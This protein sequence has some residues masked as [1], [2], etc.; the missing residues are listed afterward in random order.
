MANLHEES[1]VSFLPCRTWV[2]TG[3]AGFIGSHLAKA[4]VARGKAPNP[5][6]RR[7]FPKSG[8]WGLSR[9]YLYRTRWR[10]CGH[11]LKIRR[12]EKLN[13]PLFGLRA[14]L[15]VF[16]LIGNFLIPHQAKIKNPGSYKTRSLF[17]Y[18]YCQIY[19][20]GLSQIP[21]VL[22]RRSCRRC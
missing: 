10:K 4:L 2:I 12:S 1:A 22:C 19:F 17:I 5:L 11:S 8:H 14:Y 21:P 7:I 18:G 3:G 9:K 16:L 13:L 15:A 20:T 6:M